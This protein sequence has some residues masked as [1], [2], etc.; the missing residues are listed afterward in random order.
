MEQAFPC[1]SQISS[2]CYSI[3]QF[4]GDG[5]L[6]RWV[7]F[8]LAHC[9]NEQ[10][11]VAQPAAGPTW[12]DNPQ[13]GKC[14]KKRVH[15]LPKITNILTALEGDIS[16]TECCPDLTK[17]VGFY[18]L[19]NGV[20]F[21]LIE[22]SEDL[23]KKSD[24]ISPTCDFGHILCTNHKLAHANQYILANLRLNLVMLHQNVSKTHLS[25]P[26]ESDFY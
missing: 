1:N 23:E 6:G 16:K 22:K 15:N 21:N 3:N 14:K 19:Y 2:T 4:W 5:V 12:R 7:T 13:K 11:T 24:H 18:K 17:V 25:V 20:K 10:T 9:G 26:T 8:G